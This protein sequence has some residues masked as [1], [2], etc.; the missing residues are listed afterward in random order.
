MGKRVLE[1]I[2]CLAGGIKIATMMIRMAYRTAVYLLDVGMSSVR[3]FQLGYHFHVAVQAE[4][5]LGSFQ[6]L[7][8]SATVW[9]EFG[10]RAKPTA[11]QAGMT[12]RCQQSGTECLAPAQPEHHTETG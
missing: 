6:G 8:A 2:E 7:V 12:D 5:A 10:V 3:S 11:L 4:L 1:V 9:L